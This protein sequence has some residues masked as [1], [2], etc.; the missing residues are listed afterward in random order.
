M[1]HIYKNKV[2]E[3]QERLQLIEQMI[4]TAKG[5]IKDESVFYLL[6]GWLVFVAAAINYILMNY[7]TY[8][9]PWIAWPFIMILGGIVSGIVGFIKGKKKK[10]Q[11]YPER[12]LKYLWIAFIVVLLSVLFGMPRVGIE[13][14]YP[15]LMLL[16]GLGT[17]V[18]GGI[19][20][21]KP[22]IIGGIVAWI[23]GIIAFYCNFSEQ[24]LL[25]MLAI[26]ASYIIP[27]HLLANS[28]ESYV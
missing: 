27:G 13:A 21:F 19:L 14:T 8:D 23:C 28:K 17:F 6:W 22:L 12:S 15:I 4:S 18:S 11:T 5:N 7:T 26:L 24:L 9:K 3:N 25:I 1:Q 10:V 16:Y 2:M 20:K